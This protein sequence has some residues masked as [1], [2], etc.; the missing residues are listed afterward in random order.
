MK[1]FTGCYARKR[2]ATAVNVNT[3]AVAGESVKPE[4][5]CLSRIHKE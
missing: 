3:T 4:I 1:G 5:Q 2:T